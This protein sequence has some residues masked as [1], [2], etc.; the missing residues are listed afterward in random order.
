MD[1]RP[2]AAAGEFSSRNQPFGF[3]QLIMMITVVLQ[4]FYVFTFNYAPEALRFVVAG[5]LLAIHFSMSP[6]ALGKKGQLWQA[7]ILTSIALTM[8][9][10][11]VAHGTHTTI[12]EM[13]VPE[14]LRNLAM[15]IMPL[16]LFCFPEHLPHRFLC[17]IALSSI[18][19]GGAIALTGDPVYVSGTP[20]L[21]S[22]TGGLTQ[23]HP[24]AKF[25]ALQLL[26]VYQY[27]YARLL[28]AKL[29]LPIMVFASAILVGYG[30]RNEILFVFAYFSWLLYFRYRNVPAVKWSPPVLIALL[31]VIS[32]A[33]LQLGEDVQKW[34]SGRIGVWE[35]RLDLIWSRDL[36]TFLFGGG[37]GADQIWNPQWWWMDQAAAHNDFLHITMESGLVGLIA[38]VIFIVAL[39]M[40]LPGSSKALV[41]ALVV[42]SMFSNGQFQSPLIA[43]NYFLLATASI[44]CWQRRTA[45][46]GLRQRRRKRPAE[47]ASTVERRA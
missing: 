35:H 46:D 11:S 44:F 15:F 10:W 38:V 17:I 22:I 23:M 31:I 25:I 32:A 8:V 43:L 39:L 9:S 1:Y 29:A 30:G 16:W 13:T 28:D 4:Y 7:M 12:V 20:R 18:I 41:V 2:S 34:G 26:L 37:L 3:V 19:L 45:L 5:A 42:E 14:V 6:Y 40:R 47:P 24:S 33:A 21:G 36:L 27:Y